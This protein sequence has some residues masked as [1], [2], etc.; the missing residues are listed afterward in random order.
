ML[1]MFIFDS[2]PIL[3]EKHRFSVFTLSWEDNGTT[4]IQNRQGEAVNARLWIKHSDSECGLLLT[5][6]I[7]YSYLL[8]VTT[9]ESLASQ[10]VSY[11]KGWDDLVA[12]SCAQFVGLRNDYCSSSDHD[13][14]MNNDEKRKKTDKKDEKME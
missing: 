3:I 14:F 5:I 6:H 1:I 11:M 4:C 10:K 8:N 9:N 12:I 13:G 7:M 2:S